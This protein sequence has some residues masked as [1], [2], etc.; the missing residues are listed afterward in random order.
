MIENFIEREYSN[1]VNEYS[2]DSLTFTKLVNTG[3]F[4]EAGQ[5]YLKN[6]KAGKPVYCLAPKGSLENEMFWNEEERRCMEGYKIGDLKITGR[7][8]FYLNYFM[9]LRVPEGTDKNKTNVEKEE[10][11]PSFWLIQYLWWNFKTIA[12]YGGKFAGLTSQGGEDICCVKTRGAGFSYM[13]AAD[14]IY[15]YT[16]IPKSKSYIFAYSSEYLDGADGIMPKIQNG[17][18]FL[19]TATKSYLPNGKLSD[20]SRWGLNRYDTSDEPKEFK[21][22]YKDLSGVIYGRD[23]QIISVICDKPRKARGKRGRKITIEEAG[24]FPNVLDIISTSQA[25]VKDGA[26][27]V[28]QIV[29]FGTGGEEGPGIQGLE[30]VFNNPKA[31]NMM[32]FPNIFGE[33]PNDK[34]GFFCPSFFANSKFMDKDGNPEIRKAIDSEEKIRNEKKKVSSKEV[35]RHTAEYPFTPQ[36]ALKRVK[37]NIFPTIEIN[38]QLQRL[39]AD[40]NKVNSILCVDLSIDNLGDIKLEPAQNRPVSIY[41]HNKDEYYEGC[42]QI[43]QKPFKRTIFGSVKSTVPRD[44]Y[45]IT[46]DNYGVDD[47]EDK[48]SLFCA[49][50]WKQ[51]NKYD[52][53]YA[54]LPVAWYRGRPK[55]QDKAFNILMLMS[56]LYG[57]A[58]IHGEYNAQ[59]VILINFFKY[60]HKLHLIADSPDSMVVDEQRKKTKWSKISTDFK[61]SALKELA[62]WFLEERGYTINEEE[63]EEVDDDGQLLNTNSLLNI[64]FV[65]DEILLKECSEY[66]GQNADSISS[67]LLAMGIL[68]EKEFK[69][70]ESMKNSDKSDFFSRFIENN[71]NNIDNTLLIN[72]Y[73]G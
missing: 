70:K 56:M 46:V 71:S 55:F 42:V 29:M 36:E 8:Y 38:A 25:L 51:Y 31:F 52:N 1:K 68:K 26:Y 14:D 62:Q 9:I 37:G 60:K 33:N 22:G 32:Q 63:E 28:G 5:T 41:P 66:H 12:H 59:G 24:S 49:Y 58:P 40:R 44:M 54:R 16:F 72:E 69:T 61:A 6:K 48:T 2:I 17:L 73:N 39:Q 11:F 30:S 65:D 23:S 3:L 19:R 18:N 57:N 43:R 4:S 50:V 67:A 13:D 10:S 53:S 47:A 35:D 34:V 7:M 21:S 15:N 45:F 20:D 27:K 64:H